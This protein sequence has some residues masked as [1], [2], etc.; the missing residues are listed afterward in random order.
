MTTSKDLHQQITD[1]IAAAIEAGAPRFKMPWHQPRGSHI[2]PVNV[3]SGK[4]YQGINIV[5]LWLTGEQKGYLAPIWGTYRQWNA[6]GAQVRRGEKAAPIVFYKEL[7]FDRVDETTGESEQGRTLFAR[8]S[9]VFN[10]DQVDGY[11]TPDQDPAPPPPLIDCI[12]RADALIA[13]SGADVR[14]GGH[15]AF[16]A[17]GE[18]FIMVPDRA[19]FVG[20][21]TMSATEAFYTTKLHELTHWTGHKS[22]LARDFSGRFG[23]D[24]YAFE[25]LIAGLG[26]AYLCADLGVTPQLRDDHAAYVASWLKVM[27]ADN[28]AI[29]TAAAQAQKA[30]DFL[31]AFIDPAPARPV[32]SHDPARPADDIA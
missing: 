17:P 16:Y 20:S 27:R 15:R 13:A 31:L 26:E 23:S 3:A 2:R 24:A 21:E 28:R 8:A 14:E 18:D 6:I 12:A 25:E 5:T 29:F 30:A 9:H 32:A 7:T 1:Q 4:R 10:A 19:L 22:R 11:E